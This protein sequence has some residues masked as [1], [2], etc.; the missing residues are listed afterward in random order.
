[1]AG[2]RNSSLKK[3]MQAI[4]ALI[5][6]KSGNWNAKLGFVFSK[7]MFFLMRLYDRTV[8]ENFTLHPA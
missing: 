2:A 6:I 5:V 7:L 1:M 4:Q 3:V 8:S